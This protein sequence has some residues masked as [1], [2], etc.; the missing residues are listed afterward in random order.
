MSLA[1]V[2]S[3]IC[4][5]MPLFAIAHV[6]TI[7]WRRDGRFADGQQYAFQS[8][9]YIDDNLV[10][11]ARLP[12]IYAFRD[13]FGL[14]DV[15]QDTKDTFKGSGISYQAYE[16]AEGGLHYGAGRQKRIRAGLRYSRGGQA[17][18]W[19]PQPGDEARNKGERGPL[20]ALRHRVDERLAQREGYA[21]L[22]PKQADRVVRPDPRRRSSAGD[23]SDDSDS[24]AASLDFRSVD[25]DEENMYQRARRIG[26]AG[27]PNVDVTKENRKRKQREVEDG[28][29]AG[30]WTRG[31]G[32]RGTTPGGRYNGV[33]QGR[34]KG[35]EKQKANGGYY[36]GCRLRVSLIRRVS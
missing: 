35:K 26:Y 21:P 24:D 22:L 15:W 20:T 34:A 14:K 23:S 19:L 10:H 16:P 32:G 2:D 29:L 12:F 25:E 28:I 31:A 7:Y 1:L 13:S 3:L 6:S 11:T 4:F 18:Y 36:G 9:D 27:F 30:K 17:K 8:S 5:E 33:G